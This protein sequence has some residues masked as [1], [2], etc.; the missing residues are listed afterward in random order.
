MSEKERQK[1]ERLLLQ[2]IKK[3]KPELD[4]MLQRMSDHWSYEDAVYRFYHHSFKVYGVQETTGQAV[5]LLKKLLPEKPFNSV[6]AR[7]VADGTGHEFDFSHNQDWERHT[8]PLLEAFFHTKFMIEM[9]VRYAGLAE[10]PE[11]LPS[12]WAALLYLFDLR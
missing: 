2:R 4:A 1:L 11:V 12:G 9:A 5:D 8:R 10:P 6:F 3:Y 7:I